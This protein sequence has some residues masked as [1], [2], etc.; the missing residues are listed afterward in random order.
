MR[1]GGEGAERAGTVPNEEVEDE[2]LA[3]TLRVEIDFPSAPRRA[4]FEISL[5]PT[6]RGPGTVSDSSS[7]RRE[8]GRGRGSRDIS[9]TMESNRF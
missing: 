7:E 1:W 8:L 9:V 3:N 6:S 4:K 5:K 2:S